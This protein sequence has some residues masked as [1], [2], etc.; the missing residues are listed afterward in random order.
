VF[1]EN[2]HFYEI[3]AIHHIKIKFS[4]IIAKWKFKTTKELSYY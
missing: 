1:Y 4:V 3:H 2:L